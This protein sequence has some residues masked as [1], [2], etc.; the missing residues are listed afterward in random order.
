MRLT[1]IIRQYVNRSAEKINNKI[2][3]IESNKIAK[4]LEKEELK[5]QKHN[6]REDRKRKRKLKFCNLKKRATFVVDSLGCFFGD[7]KNLAYKLKLTPRKKFALFYAVCDYKESVNRHKNLIKMLYKKAGIGYLSKDH[8]NDLFS[9]ES[10]LIAI[11]GEEP[12]EHKLINKHHIDF[13]AKD[14]KIIEIPFVHTL[15]ILCDFC[16]SAYDL[17]NKTV[18]YEILVRLFKDKACEYEI[19]EVLVRYFADCIYYVQEKNLVA[20]DYNYCKSLYD[21]NVLF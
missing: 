12:P 8:D 20:P 15:E 13:W 16:A 21:R 4:D 6:I 10:T 9:K 11:R 1:T 17:Q 14:N 7:V 18:S 5:I 2:N 3:I 19:S